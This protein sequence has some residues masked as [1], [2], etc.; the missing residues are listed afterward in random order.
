M[1]ANFSLGSLESVELDR[2]LLLYEKV[3]DRLQDI[4]REGKST[5]W[6]PLVRYRNR[7]QVRRKFAQ[8]LRPSGLCRPPAI[9]NPHATI[10]AHQPFQIL[11]AH[12]ELVLCAESLARGLLSAA[13]PP[14]RLLLLLGAACNA[15]PAKAPVR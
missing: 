10:E 3:F 6:N 2:A 5:E 9:D 11:A 8:E 7:K 15:R 1:G 14:R 13:G 4:R 12:G